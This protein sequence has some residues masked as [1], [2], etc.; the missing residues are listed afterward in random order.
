MLSLSAFASFAIFYPFQYFLVA[1][2]CLFLTF[3]TSTFPKNKSFERFS[4]EKNCSD[5][6]PLA[7]MTDFKSAASAFRTAR[8]RFSPIFSWDLRIRQY[9]FRQFGKS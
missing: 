4:G 8:H 2:I 5:V 6:F 3:W 7:E 1:V 9:I